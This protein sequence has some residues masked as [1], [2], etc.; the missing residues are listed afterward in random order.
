MANEDE[1]F[2]K[3]FLGSIQ[4]EF[5]LSDSK[6]IAPIEFGQAGRL[7][8]SQKSISLFLTHFVAVKF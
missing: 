4:L 8:S 3:T 2:L 6:F 5:Y 7:R 1:N